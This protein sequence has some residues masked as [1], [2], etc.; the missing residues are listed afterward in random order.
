M[1]DNVGAGRGSYIWG[2]SVHNVRIERLWGDV[3]SQVGQK[4]HLFFTKLELDHG[5]DINNT[6]HILLL[7]FLFLPRINDNLDQFTSGWNLHHI[8]GRGGPHRSPMDMFGWDMFTNGIRGAQLAPNVYMTE[9]ELEYYGVDFQ[10][11]DEGNVAESL[12]ARSAQEGNAPSYFGRI[13][14]QERLN[15]IPVETEEPDWPGEVL[16]TLQ[17]LTSSV[18]GYSDDAALSMLW[19]RALVYMRGYFGDHV[20]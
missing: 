6:D 2:R 14:P 1:Q 15:H 18:Q 17:L 16:Y 3:T 4:W 19:T 12:E 7:H 10:L 8:T 11:L 13:P 9:E 20:F 5:L